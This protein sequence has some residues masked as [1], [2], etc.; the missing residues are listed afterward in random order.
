VSRRTSKERAGHQLGQADPSGA[1]DLGEGD[2][3]FDGAP[4]AS[5]EG[6]ETL[7]GDGCSLPG[8]CHWALLSSASWD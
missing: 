7:V 5:A 6:E 4:D 8:P 2:P 3:R 1:L